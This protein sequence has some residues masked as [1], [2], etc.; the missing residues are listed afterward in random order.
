MI[1]ALVGTVAIVAGT[2]IGGLPALPAVSL[3]FL[4]PN[5]DLIWARLRRRPF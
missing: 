5:A 4:V 2:D 1:A 3:G